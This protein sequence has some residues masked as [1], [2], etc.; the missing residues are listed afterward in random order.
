MQREHRTDRIQGVLF[1]AR[2]TIFAG[3]SLHPKAL[4]LSARQF[5][6]RFAQIGRHHARPRPEK[7]TTHYRL[8]TDATELLKRFK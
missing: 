4:L 7:V 6:R 5:A 8:S 2:P 3:S 1:G